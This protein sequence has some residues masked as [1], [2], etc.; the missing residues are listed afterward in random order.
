MSQIK[1][2]RDGN[3]ENMQESLRPPMIFKTKF[4]RTLHPPTFPTNTECFCSPICHICRAKL[5]I[6]SV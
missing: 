4:L 2:E 5:T 1:N 6:M 3:I